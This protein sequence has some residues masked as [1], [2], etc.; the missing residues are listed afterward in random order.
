MGK[1]MKYNHAFDIGF[2]VVSDK[3]NAS[4]VTERE[5]LKGLMRRI[6]VLLEEPEG[7]F[8]EATDCFDTFEVED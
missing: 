1:N 6:K 4:E 3:A 5:L 8:H 2:E 7:S